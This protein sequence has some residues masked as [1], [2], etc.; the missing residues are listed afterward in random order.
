[1]YQYNKTHVSRGSHGTLIGNWN[2]ERALQQQSTTTQSEHTF[3]RTMHYNTHNNTQTNSHNNQLS[4]TQ[5]TYQ[6]PKITSDTKQPVMYYTARSNWNTDNTP[7]NFTNTKTMSNTSIIPLTTNNNTTQYETTDTN[8]SHT[9]PS[10]DAEPSIE[11]DE[12]AD[13]P[14]DEPITTSKPPVTSKPKSKSMYLFICHWL[15]C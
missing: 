7:H 14:V 3:T 10:V 12:P 11:N 4:V 9:P 6:I 2:E 5:L 1:M 13:V 15:N 8:P